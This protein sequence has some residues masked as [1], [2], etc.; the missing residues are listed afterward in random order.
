[1]SDSSS[2]NDK[3]VD[4]VSKS[5]WCS[6]SLGLLCHMNTELGNQADRKTQESS[7]MDPMPFLWKG[8]EKINSISGIIS[9]SIHLGSTES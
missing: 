8:I 6:E 3:D 4:R 9:I 5:L 1:M 7:L 2:V